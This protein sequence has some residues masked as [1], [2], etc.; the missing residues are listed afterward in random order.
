MNCTRR[1]FVSGLTLAGTAGLLGVRPETS[2]AEA[3]AE[4][5]RLVLAQTDSICHEVQYLKDAGGGEARAVAAG[6]AHM[7][8]T[9]A[10]PLL[11]RIDGGAPVVLLAG[12]HV[13]C[14]ELFGHESVR[15]SAISK[16]RRSSRLPSDGNGT[17]GAR[18]PQGHQDHHASSSGGGANLRRG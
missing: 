14:L 8:L 18:S 11:T 4:T 1:E 9:F 2:S 7:T 13:G 12:G 5:K 16:A 3:P 6:E 17:R 15:P 10:G